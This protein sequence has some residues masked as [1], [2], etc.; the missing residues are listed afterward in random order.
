M[1]MMKKMKKIMKK[2]IAMRV[3]NQNKLK[4]VYLFIKEK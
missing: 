4:K 3:K 2:K 1:I